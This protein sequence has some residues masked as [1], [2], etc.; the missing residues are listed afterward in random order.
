MFKYSPRE[1]TKAWK[2][3]NDVPEETKTRRLMEIISLQNK[4]SA[5]KNS[6]EKGKIHEILIDGYSK[7]SKNMLKGRT[8]GNKTVVIPEAGHKPG[9]FVKVKINGSNSATLFGIPIE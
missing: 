1:R 8:D 9:D 2:M 5:E 4:I 7:K 3:K 6:E